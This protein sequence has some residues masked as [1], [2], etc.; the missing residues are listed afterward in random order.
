MISPSSLVLPILSLLLLISR[1]IFMRL[2]GCA[3]VCM[4]FVPHLRFLLN[5]PFLRII[6]SP[7]PSLKRLLS[8]FL[9]L[10]SGVLFSCPNSLCQPGVPAL[11]ALQFS[12][13]EGPFQHLFSLL[14]LFWSLDIS[15]PILSLVLLT[16]S[17]L[18]LTYVPTL[19]RQKKE[20][21]LTNTTP[22]F[23]KQLS[24]KHYPRLATFSAPKP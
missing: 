22:S 15:L 11:Q 9:H 24:L 2:G 20:A 13:P 1:R 8:H 14:S 16:V 17:P 6:I 4:S 12:S 5:G 19:L 7:L 3:E 21:R 10:Y 23:S 18:L